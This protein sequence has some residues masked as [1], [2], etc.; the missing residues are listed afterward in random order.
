MPP[1][2]YKPARFLCTRTVNGRKCPGAFKNRSGLTQHI[3]SIHSVVPPLPHSIPPA[4]SS[5]ELPV[6]SSQIH[7]ASDNEN[8]TTL[9]QDHD[10]DREEIDEHKS[11]SHGPDSSIPVQLE[12][13]LHCHPILD[14]VFY[15][16]SLHSIVSGML[17]L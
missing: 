4:Q 5:Q 3:N 12:R 1:K 9:E 17:T 14:G 13:R 15:F 8:T 7:E 6:L 2:V 11:Q 10:S 16:T